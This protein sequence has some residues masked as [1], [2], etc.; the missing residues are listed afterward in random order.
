MCNVESS[1]KKFL[2]DF[3]EARRQTAEKTIDDKEQQH[4]YNKL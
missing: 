4:I 3:C 2:M 1:V